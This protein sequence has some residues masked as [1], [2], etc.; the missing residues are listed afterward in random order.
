MI[1]S[2]G[3]LMREWDEADALGRPAV[4]VEVDEDYCR[5]AAERIAAEQAQLSL[6]A[7]EAA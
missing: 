4:G 1:P 3:E 5:I 7:G 6:L 2:R